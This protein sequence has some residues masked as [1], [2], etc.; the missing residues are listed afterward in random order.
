MLFRRIYIGLIGCIFTSFLM[1]V[2]IATAQ[3]VKKKKDDEKTVAYKENPEAKWRAS[4]K[5][6]ITFPMNCLYIQY[7]E[8]YK[9]F[10][11]AAMEMSIASPDSG[12]RISGSVDD[13]GN[14]EIK[15]RLRWI[16]Y[17]VK[18]LVNKTNEELVR[19]RVSEDVLEPYVEFTLRCIDLQYVNKTLL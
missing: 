10:K 6:R 9:M 18:L 19:V 8:P 13:K 15:G 4:F 12:R 7:N 3:I 2:G 5:G 17:V 1:N 11:V 14:F 16:N